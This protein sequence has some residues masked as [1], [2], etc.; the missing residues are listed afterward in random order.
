MR[1]MLYSL[2]LTT[3]LA[4]PLP[5]Q[6]AASGAIAGVIRDQIEAFQA[7]DFDTAFTFASPMIQGM[8][9][10][11]DNFGA[12]VQNGYPMVHRPDGVRFLELSDEGGVPRQKVMIRDG[13]GALHML[14]YEMIET[15]AGWRI[16]GVRFLRMPQVGA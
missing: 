5:A 1:Q 2:A 13:A 7:D 6:E 14:E 11:A 8:F 15:E 12:M 10:D 4:A 9:R 3:A 16:N